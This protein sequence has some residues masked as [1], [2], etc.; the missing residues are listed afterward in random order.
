MT[1]EING[2]G[3]INNLFHISIVIQQILKV[4]ICNQKSQKFFCLPTKVVQIRRAYIEK[5]R[6]T[7][8]FT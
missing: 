2:I 1:Y 3:S 4:G 7:T 8:V 5:K 6:T